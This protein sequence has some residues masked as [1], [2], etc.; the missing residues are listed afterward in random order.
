MV[1]QEDLGADEEGGGISTVPQAGYL[2]LKDSA[3]HAEMAIVSAEEVRANKQTIVPV[4]P[5]PLEQHR[6][7]CGADPAAGQV[8][9]ERRRRER[10][11]AR[12]WADSIS[13]QQ[14]T[15]RPKECIRFVFPPTLLKIDDVILRCWL[16]LQAMATSVHDIS[17]F[18]PPVSFWLVLLRPAPAPSDHAINSTTLHLSRH[19][20]FFCF[21]LHLEAVTGSAHDI[22]PCV[23]PVFFTRYLVSCATPPRPPPKSP[24][25]KTCSRTVFTG[26]LNHCGKQTNKQTNKRALPVRRLIKLS[27]HLAAP[28]C[29]RLKW[30]PTLSK[31]PAG[32]G[33]LATLTWRRQCTRYGILRITCT[34]YEVCD[35]PPMNL[36]GN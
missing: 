21:R 16:H 12:D 1:E 19:I 31:S 9:P 35:L 34:R 5:T 14:D 25:S 32:H 24:F 3:G 13:H 17:R 20:V 4:L 28:L 33:M 15:G 36:L 30:P 23:P 18:M 11:L 10:K 29:R 7:C 6:T 22:L 26:N 27:G 8:R 2:E